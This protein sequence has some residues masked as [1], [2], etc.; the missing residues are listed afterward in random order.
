MNGEISMYKGMAIS[1]DLYTKLKKAGFEVESVKKDQ[2]GKVVSYFGKVNLVSIGSA[3]Y[4]RMEIPP[5]IKKIADNFEY[6]L[7]TDLIL[8]YRPFHDI[9]NWIIDGQQR[10]GGAR[11]AGMTFLYGTLFVGLTYM[12]EANLFYH[13]NNTPKKMASWVKFLAAMEGGMKSHKEMLDLAHRMKLTTPTSPGVRK[14]SDADIRSPHTLLHACSVGGLKM[15]KSVLEIMRSWKVEGR[16]P[17]EANNAEIIRGLCSFLNVHF[18]GEQ[19]LPWATI[20]MV[21]RKTSPLE[22]LAL[23]KKEVT[24][25]RPD[26]RQVSDAL[27]QMFGRPKGIISPKLVKVA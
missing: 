16:M 18:Y 11:L 25:G 23:A 26:A 27:S 5:H 24:K 3:S 17:K 10:S 15:L 9:D 22:L 2:N 14:N 7:C 20:M 21:L 13:F 1:K 8:S 4:Q 12:E 6:R 19:S